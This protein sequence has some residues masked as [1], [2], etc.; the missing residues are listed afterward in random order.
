M[1]LDSFEFYKG[2]KKPFIFYGVHIK[3]FL[4]RLCVTQPSSESAIRKTEVFI[5]KDITMYI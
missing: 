1:S 2:E 5:S 3:I 4:S